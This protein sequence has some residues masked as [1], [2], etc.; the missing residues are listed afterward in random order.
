MHVSEARLGGPLI[1]GLDT[2]D[3]RRHPC[4]DEDLRDDG[5]A[6]ASTTRRLLRGTV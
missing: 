4:R 2:R 1:T 3:Q 5:E 6:E